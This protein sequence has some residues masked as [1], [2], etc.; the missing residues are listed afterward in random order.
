MM[1]FLSSAI[2]SGIAYDFIKKGIDFTTE[3]LKKALAMWVVDDETVCAIADRLKGLGLNEDMSEKA[4]EKKIAQS[5]ELV[6]ILNRVPRVRSVYI[7]NQSH[8]GSGDNIGHDKVS[9]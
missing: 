2:V 4:I 6:S 9:K 5:E 8:T 7:V 1:K 3:P